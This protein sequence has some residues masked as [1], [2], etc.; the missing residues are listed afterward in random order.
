ML[1]ERSQKKTNAIWFHLYVETKNSNR[2]RL[3]DTEN[4]LVVARGKGDGGMD[5]ILIDEG[6]YEVQP[7]SHTI[8]KPW[9]YNVQ[10]RE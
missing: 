1:R 3:I 5:K 2:N 7:C 8:N 10:H 6:D 9:G 4:K